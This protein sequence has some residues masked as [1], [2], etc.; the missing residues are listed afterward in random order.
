MGRLDVRI[1]EA[2]NL[3]N[4]ELIGKPDPYVKVEIENALHKTSVAS[5]TTNPKWD[6]VFKFVVA[7]PDSAQLSLKL[8]NKN[9]VGDSFMGEYRMNL[10][11]LEKGNVK[12]TWVL[13][14]QCKTNAEIHIRLLA[15]DFGRDP[16]PGTAAAPQQ[17][18]PPPQQP[19]V[20]Q[21]PVIY[22]Q[23]VVMQQQPVFQQQPIVYQQQPMMQQAPPMM[24]QQPMGFQQ[25]QYPP[26]QYP[27]QG[28]RPQQ[29]QVP[30]GAYP[31]QYPQQYPG[32]QPMGGYPQQPGYP[33]QQGF[34]P[35]AYPG[36]PGYRY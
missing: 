7:D 13:L 32:Q 6:E 21:Q 5:G 35:A 28:F 30:M 22:Q 31:G 14:Q 33:Q 19:I 1:V 2:R 23:P 9:L 12:D 11:G 10:S 20:Q 26:Q 25:P 3:P 16:A 8:W 17:V 15:H 4:T 29:Q 24:M 18:T 27:Q 34:N 36:Q